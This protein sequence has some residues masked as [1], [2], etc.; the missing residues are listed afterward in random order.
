[1]NRY[2]DPELFEK[3]NDM[4]MVTYLKLCGYAPQQVQW[5]GQTCYWFFRVTDGLLDGI[6]AFTSGNALVE[7]R[8]YNRT[9]TQTKRDFYEQKQQSS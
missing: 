6:D 4:A 9:F 8:E 7:P 1:M 2:M 5:Q 3:S